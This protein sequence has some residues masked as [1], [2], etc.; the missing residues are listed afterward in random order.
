MIT[1]NFPLVVIIFLYSGII[2]IGQNNISFIDSIAEKVCEDLQY[3]DQIKSLEDPD[4]KIILGLA[5]L[6]Y[7]DEWVS[8]N[9]EIM[10]DEK[11]RISYLDYLL[12]HRLLQI[13]PK[14][15]ELDN[16][17]Q[18][19]V[20][21]DDR[22]KKPYLTLKN[23]VI[24]SE[25]QI[26]SEQ[27]CKYFSPDLDRSELIEKINQLQ[28]CLQKYKKTSVLFVNNRTDQLYYYVSVLDYASGDDIAA[29]MFLFYD[30]SDDLIDDW[31]IKIKEELIQPDEEIIID[32][33]MIRI[34]R[35]EFQK[36]EQDTLKN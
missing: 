2:S 5:I 18:M 9:K 36:S 7:N 34:T 21:S 25:S 13:C 33:E 29:I 8:L 11:F 19:R 23:F 16:T 32:E 26:I 1:K 20:F 28:E 10:K 3:N 6:P 17:F 31:D 24:E 4:F 12:Q 27:L 35:E 22:F 14:Y 15:R 30:T